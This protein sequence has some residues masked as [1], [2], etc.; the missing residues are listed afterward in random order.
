METFS[1]DNDLQ[2]EPLLTVSPE[3]KYYLAKTRKWTKF[4]AII[5]FVGIGLMLILSIFMGTLLS[6]LPQPAFGA[7][8]F[9]SFMF[10]IIY[11]LMAA[12]YFAPVMYLYKHSKHSDLAL[13]TNSDVELTNSFKYLYKHYQYVGIVSVIIL[14]LYALVFIGSFIVAMAASAI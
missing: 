7:T 6:S 8:P 10:T 14:S 2:H 11:L 3:A 9:P 5:G 13:K 1:N 4:F 12:I